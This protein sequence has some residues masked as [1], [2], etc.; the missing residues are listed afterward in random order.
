M[1][2]DVTGWRE[3]P[4]VWTAPWR[5]VQPVACVAVP[6]RIASALVVADQATASS[7]AQVESV[8][9]WWNQALD[10]A[11]TRSREQGVPCGWSVAEPD[12]LVCGLARQ[13]RLEAV[14]FEARKRH[15][16]DWTQL[17]RRLALN[18]PSD[19][20]AA[21]RGFSREVDPAWAIASAPAVVDEEAAA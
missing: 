20:E 7:I 19:A 12:G 14:R 1:A 17:R 15:D 21:H 16:A 4:K 2:P 10:Q 18:W 9:P 13:G 11:L 6:G 8:R 3:A 5:A